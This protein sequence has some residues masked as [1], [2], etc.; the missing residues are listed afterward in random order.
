LRDAAIE[1]GLVKGEDFDQWVRPEDM[2]G[3]NM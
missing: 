3:P 2:L 1:L